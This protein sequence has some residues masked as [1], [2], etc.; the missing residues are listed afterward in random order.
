L[1][2][3]TPTAKKMQDETTKEEEASN[4]GPGEWSKAA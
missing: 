4:G 1:S 3:S 2:T